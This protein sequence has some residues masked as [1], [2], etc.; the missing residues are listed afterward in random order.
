MGDCRLDAAE[1]WTGWWAGWRVPGMW[2]WV[3]GWGVTGPMCGWRVLGP[4]DGCALLVLVCLCFSPPSYLAPSHSP[5]LARLVNDCTEDFMR[6]DLEA[7]GKVR[8]QPPAH[9]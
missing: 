6:W 7:G 3:A 9:C 2:F 5:Q 8:Q 4:A 1:V